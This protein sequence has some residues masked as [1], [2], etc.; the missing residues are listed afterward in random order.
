MIRSNVRSSEDSETCLSDDS[1]RRSN[2]AAV[3]TIHTI[4]AVCREY[5]SLVVA[6]P[7]MIRSRGDQSDQLTA[8]LRNFWIA[9][10]FW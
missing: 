8:P 7:V 3:F 5:R 10:T 1:L 4:S 9:I 2:G 6:E